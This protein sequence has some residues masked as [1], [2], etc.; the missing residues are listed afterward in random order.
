MTLKP[1]IAFILTDTG[2][3]LHLPADDTTFEYPTSGPD[4]Q[5]TRCGRSGRVVIK[6]RYADE[7]VCVT[8]LWR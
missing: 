2:H 1:A 5:Q 8:C 4:R 3:K 6:G 7:D